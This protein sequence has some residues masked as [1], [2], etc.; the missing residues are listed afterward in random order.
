MRAA[1]NLDMLADILN[2]LALAAD[3]TGDRS[4]AFAALDEASAIARTLGD[5]ALA[6]VLETNRELLKQD[7]GAPQL[8]AGAP[9][10]EMDFFA[11]LR[12]IMSGEAETAS[13][14]VPP[15]ILSRLLGGPS[16]GE[17]GQVEP[18]RRLPR[19]TSPTVK[20]SPIYQFKATLRSVKPPIWR[21]F[22]VRSGIG[23]RVLHDTL[24]VIM[25]W[26]DSHLHE[27]QAA[28]MTF[29]M[30]EVDW[31]IYDHVA[32]DEKRAR[33]DQVV[34]EERQKIKYLYD[35]GDGWEVDLVLEKILPP[36]PKGVYP[37]CVKG[38]RNGPPDDSGGPWGYMEMLEIIKDR[39][40]PN[41]EELSEWLPEDFDPEEFSLAEI[42]RLLVRLRK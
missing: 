14:T 3:V 41:H 6:L 24:Q 16:L 19:K 33:L 30:P 2:S 26:Y 13:F 8:P 31:D 37:V 9:G 23:L 5:E 28:G 17:A 40:H 7:R 4:R 25:G 18:L 1:G 38:K 11:A 20:N 32:Y 42:N 36:D 39:T 15:D 12:A 29:S 22:L 27:F 10:E 21:R 34:T 35:F